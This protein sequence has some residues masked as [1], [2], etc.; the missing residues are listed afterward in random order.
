MLEHA[1][2]HA[3]A[4]LALGRHHEARYRRRGRRQDLDQMLGLLARGADLDPDLYEAGVARVEAMMLDGRWERAL[5]LLER[6]RERRPDRPWLDALAGTCLARPGTYPEA[7]AAYERAF[8]RMTAAERFPFEG[9]RLIANPYDL[10]RFEVLPPGAREDFLRIFWRSKDPL[11]V[12]RVNERQVEHWRRVVMADLL[13][14]HRRLGVRGWDTA[15]GE[16]YIR[17]GAPVHTEY[18]Q[19]RCR[20]HLGPGLVPRLRGERAR[21]R[22]HLLRHGAERPV[23]P[24][25]HRLADPRRPRGLHR[26]PGVRARLRWPLDRPGGCAWPGSPAKAGAPAPRGLPGRRRR[27]AG[28]LLGVEPRRGD[29]HLRSRVERGGAARGGA[30]PRR[31]AGGRRGGTRSRA[32]DRSR[33]R[34]R[35]L[36]RRQPAPGRR[37]GGGGDAHAR[38][39]ARPLRRGKARALGARARLRGRPGSGPEPFRKG[40]L[41]VVPNPTGEVRDGELLVLYFEIYNLETEGATGRGR[42]EIRYRI[43]PADR[44]GRSIFA[45]MADAFRARTFIESSFVEESPGPTA[46][47]HLAIEASALPADRYRLDFAISYPPGSGDR[48][49]RKSERADHIRFCDE[50]EKKDEDG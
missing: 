21:A 3:G 33:A 8:D 16:M 17:Y 6:Q 28:G 43:A 37:G 18:T 1:P 46:R 2:D 40:D 39:D 24:A 4:H 22:G 10:E 42:Y 20:P 48:P 12:S 47:R 34:P 41:S 30:R 49:L 32:R 27:L 11:P 7:A 19:G 13:Y 9:L 23:L 31:R 36:H 14:R 44:A 25:V 38:R 26:A 35:R 5:H 29:R 15:R 45:R 50:H